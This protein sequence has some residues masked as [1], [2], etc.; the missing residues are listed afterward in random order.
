MVKHI[1]LWNLKS[2]LSDEERINGVKKFK[3]DL[4]A[5]KEVIPGI[6]KI[7]VIINELSSS[8]ADVMLDS[9]FVDEKALLDYQIHPEHVKVSG[10]GKSIFC[11]RMCIDYKA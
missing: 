2:E 8:N 3:T 11:N 10:L 5:L 6:I 1:I 9:T 7:E 4:E